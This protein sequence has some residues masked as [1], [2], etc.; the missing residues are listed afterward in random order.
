MENYIEFKL[1]TLVMEEERYK[2]IKSESPN[3]LNPGLAKPQSQLNLG[4]KN[5][6]LG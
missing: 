4:F 2:T 5:K 6:D 3:F 1:N